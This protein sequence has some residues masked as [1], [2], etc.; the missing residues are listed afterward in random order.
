MCCHLCRGQAPQAF[1]SCCAV[2]IV[3]TQ[4]HENFI[5]VTAATPLRGRGCLAFPLKGL[6]S[7]PSLHG[8]NAFIHFGNLICRLSVS[9]SIPPQK[10]S[11]SR[12]LGLSLRAE[13][14]TFQEIGVTL[15][16]RHPQKPPPPQSPKLGFPQDLRMLK[17]ESWSWQPNSSHSSK[18]SHS[19]IGPSPRRAFPVV[20]C[21][22]LLVLADRGD[23]WL[24]QL[25]AVTL[26]WLFCPCAPVP[27]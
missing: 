16:Q 18:Q 2:V 27:R 17:H 10:F 4:V 20:W 21:W 9:G 6:P 5:V 23:S 1:R 25:L 7:S 8:F 22:G 24:C 3:S 26:R 11:S 15:V 14:E 12:S 19:G 13:R